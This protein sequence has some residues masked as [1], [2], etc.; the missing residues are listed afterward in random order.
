MENIPILKKTEGNKYQKESSI[1]QSESQKENQCSLSLDDL[2]KIP[3]KKRA[4]EQ[5]REIRRLMAK[6]RKDFFYIYI[7]INQPWQAN[8]QNKR[9]QK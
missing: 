4:P 9:C 6:K 3:A 5:S 2:K 7:F 8:L 1:L